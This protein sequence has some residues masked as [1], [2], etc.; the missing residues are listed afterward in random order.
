MTSSS[1]IVS[2]TFKKF[3][4]ATNCSFSSMQIVQ[5][6]EL[7]EIVALNIDIFE[8]FESADGSELTLVVK[9]KLAAEKMG[10]YKFKI[11]ESHLNDD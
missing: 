1:K 4:K 2:H 8:T 3:N 7:G 5:L 10:I 9:K 11:I 6:D